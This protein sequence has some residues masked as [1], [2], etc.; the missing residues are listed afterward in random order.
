MNSEQ[1]DS[2][3]VGENSFIQKISES[4]ERKPEVDDF[5]KEGKL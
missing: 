4:T 2:V 3:A 5:Q 1:R